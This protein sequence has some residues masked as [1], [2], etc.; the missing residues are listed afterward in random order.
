M[1]DDVFE[2]L[3]LLPV[4]VLAS[5]ID[6][7]V[8]QLVTSVC[9]DETLGVDEV[10]TAAGFILGHALPHE[11]LHNLL[12]NPDTGRAGAEED[13]AVVLARQAGPL[14]SVD[15]TAE[16]DRAGSLDVIVEASVGIPIPLECG[17]GI[18]EVLELDDDT[19]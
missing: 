5:K 15:D 2:G 3:K 9:G 7:V 11:E 19:R 8:G 12:G 10:E 17:E 4:V 14:D 1:V 13:R 6:L 18:L 16:D